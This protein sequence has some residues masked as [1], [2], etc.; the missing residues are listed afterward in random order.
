LGL[1]DGRRISR[2]YREQSSRLAIRARSSALPIRSLSGGNQQ[3]V[4]IGRALALAPK[5]IVLNDPTRGVDVGTKHEVYGLLESLA[6]EGAAV[7]FLSTE[8][9]EFMGVADRVAV[10][11]GGTL[12]RVLDTADISVDKL[13]AAM[14]GHQRGS[15]EAVR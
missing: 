7:C 6:A 10:F 15:T 2:S 14:F 11:H 9:E 12:E 4:L 13:L 3:K 5:V 1:I 8:L